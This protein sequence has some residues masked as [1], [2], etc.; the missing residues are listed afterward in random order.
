MNGITLLSVDAIAENA[1]GI[2]RSTVDAI[3]ENAEEISQFRKYFQGK[4]PGAVDFALQIAMV[5][6]IFIICR[7]LIKFAMRIL[8]RSFEK[9]GVEAA[10]AHFTVSVIQAVFYI[11]LVAVLATFLGVEGTSVA[12]LIGSMGV[13]IVLALK[14]SLSN[15]AGGF[16]LLFM[17]PFVS[18]DYIHEDS[19]GNEGTVVKIDLF[20]TSLLTIDNRTVCIPNGMLSNSSLTN[21]SRQDKRQLREKVS[22]SYHADIEQAKAVIENILRTDAGILQEEPVEVVVDNLGEHGVILAWHAW[23]R[24]TEYFPTRWRITEQIKY[25]YDKAGI[26]IPYNQLDIYVRK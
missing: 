13:G 26:E 8:N 14:E 1:D 10:S 16:I 20:Y 24:P 19:K 23:V 17:K 9:A 3:V 5:I 2:A 25:Q 4:V 6:I 15:I 11:L 7:K 21:F 12:A 22:I 18:G